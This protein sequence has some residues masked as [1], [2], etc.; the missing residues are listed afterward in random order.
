[1]KRILVLAVAVVALSAAGIAYAA[2]SQSGTFQKGTSVF[3]GGHAVIFGFDHTFSLYARNGHG[4]VIRDGT[5]VPVTCATLVGNAAVLGGKWT[6]KG[7]YFEME[8]V[9]NGLPAGGP[10]GDQISPFSIGVGAAP[11]I[12]PAPGDF[13]PGQLDTVDAGDFTVHAS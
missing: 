11:T 9:D 2:L 12:C 8:V 3:G 7:Q 1:M 10:S 13:N 4:T 6:V 5:A